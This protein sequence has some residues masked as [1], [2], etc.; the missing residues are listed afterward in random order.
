MQK[1]GYRCGSRKVE[2]A[3]RSTVVKKIYRGMF[4]FANHIFQL[5]DGFNLTGDRVAGF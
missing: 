1:N 5:A 3:K 4:L 2:M